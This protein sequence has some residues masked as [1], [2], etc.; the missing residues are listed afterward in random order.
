[1][2][3][4]LVSGSLNLDLCVPAGHAE[5][6]PGQVVLHD[7]NGRLRVIP[8][9]GPD[10]LR[11]GEKRDSLIRHTGVREEFSL[12]ESLGGGLWNLL[13]SLQPICKSNY[14]WLSVTAVHGVRLP[15]RLHSEFAPRDVQEHGLPLSELSENLVLAHPDSTD[16]SILR[17][18]VD[19]I[20]GN[21]QAVDALVSRLCRDASVVVLNS[22]KWKQLAEALARHSAAY[23]VP[24]VLALTG[25][26]SWPYLLAVARQRNTVAGFGNWKEWRQF[27]SQPPIAQVLPDVPED[28]VPLELLARLPELAWDAGVH[29]E[30]LCTLG[31]GG[32][33]LGDAQTRSA[34]WIG[35]GDCQLWNEVQRRFQARPDLRNGM[36][37]WLLGRWVAEY[38]NPNRETEGLPAS[39]AAARQATQDVLCGKGVLRPSEIGLDDIRAICLMQ[40][41]SDSKL[42]RLQ[43]SESV[44]SLRS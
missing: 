6:Q 40:D 14:P 24:L 36:G 12:E 28:A 17:D 43:G 44:L 3:S 22:V 27:L 29:G 38:W 18:P 34:W 25:S 11:A 4:M 10:A 23:D 19:Q 5:C 15:H 26:P 1:M 33:V 31:K 39:V 8:H 41:E 20:Q 2:V 7:C 37:D 32:L 21:P 9:Q 16:R 35:I 42:N 13:E 30:V